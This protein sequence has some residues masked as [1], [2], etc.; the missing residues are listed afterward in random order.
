[1]KNLV[2]PAVAKIT[3][4]ILSGGSGTR[5]WPVSRRQ[6]PKQ[7]A[8]LLNDKTLFSATLA[9]VSDRSHYNRPVIVGNCE[10]KFFILE[11]LDRL[12]ITDAL[13]LLEPVGTQHRS[14]CHYD[15]II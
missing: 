11:A 4:V 5:L 6:F 12:Q 14:R 10:H 1:M 7:F 3:P 13:V 9:R 15:R 8:A 2:S